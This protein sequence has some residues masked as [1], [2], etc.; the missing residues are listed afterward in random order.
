MITRDERDKLLTMIQMYVVET[1]RAAM[2]QP[3]GPSGV[4]KV[5]NVAADELKN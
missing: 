3:L 4:S 5:T 1:A 2:Q